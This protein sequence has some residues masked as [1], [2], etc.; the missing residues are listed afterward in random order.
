MPEETLAGILLLKY[1]TISLF[2]WHELYINPCDP[3]TITQIEITILYN[4][5]A[6]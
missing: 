6:Q 5:K 2:S 1:A 4:T 3:R